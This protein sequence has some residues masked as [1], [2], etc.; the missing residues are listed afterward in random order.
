[1]PVLHDPLQ[2][3]LAAVRRLLAAPDRWL[4]DPRVE[5]SVYIALILLAPLIQLGL[6]Q[7][8]HLLFHT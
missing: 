4:D 8:G 7:I 6:E 5:F 2:G 3:W 1:V